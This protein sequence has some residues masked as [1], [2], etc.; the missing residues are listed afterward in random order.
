MRTTGFLGVCL[1]L[2]GIVFSPA[3]IAASEGEAQG[4]KEYTA[5]VEKDGI[6]R[7][8]ILAGSYYFDPASIIVKVNVPVE[9][10]V[11]KEAG[12][13]HA[14]VISAPEAGMEVNESLGTEPKVIRF[15][16]TKTGRYPFY[17]D[18][19]FLFFKTHRE[20]GMEGTL[21]VTE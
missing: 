18:K 5:T 12:I 8:A 10:T 9:L 4:K 13:P 20:R 15:T 6:Q 21:E 17:C 1:I 2:S 7:A 3:S 19:K 11:R 16:P 14:F